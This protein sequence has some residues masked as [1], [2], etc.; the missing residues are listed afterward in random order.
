M[1][2]GASVL[3]SRHRRPPCGH[4][5]LREVPPETWAHTVSGEKAAE[6][7]PDDSTVFCLPE[8]GW[9]RFPANFTFTYHALPG[10]RF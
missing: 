4:V 2:G 3:Y 5:V 10:V 1:L 7:R 9:G 6:A 8:L